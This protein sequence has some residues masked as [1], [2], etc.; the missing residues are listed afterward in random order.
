MII[1]KE[2]LGYSKAIN[3]VSTSKTNHVLCLVADVIFDYKSFFE[4]EKVCNT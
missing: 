2:N 4:I 1:P 3:L